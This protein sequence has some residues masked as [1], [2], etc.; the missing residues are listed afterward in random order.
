M[1]LPSE[2]ETEAGL[3]E[4]KEIGREVGV[5]IYGE[6][7]GDHNEGRGDPYLSEGGREWT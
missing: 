1:E 4:H 2:R 3:Q 7:L 6:R 5:H